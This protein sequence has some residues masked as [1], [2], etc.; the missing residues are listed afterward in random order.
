MPWLS[1]ENFTDT[2]EYKK[3][4]QFDLDREVT[5]GWHDSSSRLQHVSRAEDV[6]VSS[7]S[8]G[9]HFS[10]PVLGLLSM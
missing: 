8:R 4:T 9:E 7:F 1:V 2:S 5:L 6:S 3:V 10:T